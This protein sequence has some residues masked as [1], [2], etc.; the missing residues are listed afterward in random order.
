MY[1]SV[2]LMDVF[3]MDRGIRRMVL[4][5]ANP[6][7]NPL[8]AKKYTELGLEPVKLKRVLFYHRRMT[9]FES[10][11][12]NVECLEEMLHEYESTTRKTHSFDAILES[13]NERTRGELSFAD[14]DRSLTNPDP[15]WRLIGN[16]LASQINRGFSS[17]I[18]DWGVHEP[19]SYSFLTDNLY[20][21]AATHWSYN[22]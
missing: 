8:S 13:L 3:A 7:F 4:K 20:Q 21:R 22:F 9:E 19:D 16:Y 15:R 17:H 11:R 14:G 10:Y 2:E 5:L 1:D 6:T 18:R 12:H